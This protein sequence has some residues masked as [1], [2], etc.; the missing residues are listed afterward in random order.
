MSSLAT[1]VLPM[2]ERINFRC[3][4][5]GRRFK[6]EVL[7][8]NERREARREYRPNN[9]LHCPECHRTDIRRGWD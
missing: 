4:N 5:C 8:E 9:A 2:T 7:D 3:N 6:A 1:Q